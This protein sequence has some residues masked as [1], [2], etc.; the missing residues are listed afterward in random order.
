[1]G[2]RLDACYCQRTSL[3][4]MEKC[5]VEEKGVFKWQGKKILIG[6]EWRTEDNLHIFGSYLRGGHGEEVE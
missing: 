1:M 6:G 4:V 2:E 3:R 5:G